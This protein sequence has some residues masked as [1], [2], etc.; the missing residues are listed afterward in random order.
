MNNIVKYIGCNKNDEFEYYIELNG[1]KLVVFNDFGRPYKLVLG[2][3]YPV[4]FY[5]FCIDDYQ[6]EVLSEPKYGV[7]KIGEPYYAY[8]L[9]GKLYDDKLDL[10]G[11]FIEDSLFSDCEDLDGKFV[12]VRVDRISMAFVDNGKAGKSNEALG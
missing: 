7:E 4:E 3:S 10:N 2:E 11:F 5:L 8:Y 12:K 1:Q 9:Y 6:I